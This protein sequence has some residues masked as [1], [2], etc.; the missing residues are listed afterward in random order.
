M[1]VGDGQSLKDPK[2]AGMSHDK[3]KHASFL[4]SEVSL[5]IDY[6]SIIG[7]GDSICLFALLLPRP[8]RG[9]SPPP[10]HPPHLLPD[11]SPGG[12]PVLSDPICVRL[13]GAAAADEPA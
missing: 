10:P 2:K 3:P 1:Q 4:E 9:E 7:G 8:V 5:L 13:P 12:I 11:Y 6:P